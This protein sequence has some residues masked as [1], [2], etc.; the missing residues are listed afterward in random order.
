MMEVD[1]HAAFLTNKF[2]FALNILIL[3][4]YYSTELGPCLV[5]SSNHETQDC[6]ENLSHSLPWKNEKLALKYN[7]SHASAR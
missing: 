6:G 2:S 4:K 3:I 5:F 1:K 7:F